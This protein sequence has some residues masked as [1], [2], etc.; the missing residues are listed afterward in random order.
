M[1]SEAL[2]LNPSNPA[3]R[4]RCPNTH[5]LTRIC[6]KPLRLSHVFTAFICEQKCKMPSWLNAVR[7]QTLSQSFQCTF[8]C[9]SERTG[10]TGLENS[11]KFS[12]LRYF[13]ET[14]AFLWTLKNL[15]HTP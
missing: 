6:A 3:P 1:T 14:D 7:V 13:P 5:T 12:L 2:H 8:V 15:S 9:N 4:P 11:L 10:R